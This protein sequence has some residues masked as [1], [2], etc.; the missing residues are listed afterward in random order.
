MAY[1]EK[2]T[3]LLT[4]RYEE[5]F[6]TFDQL[7]LKLS[8]SRNKLSNER[9]SEYLMQGVGR[10]LS[11]L[12]KCV[13]NIFKIFPIDKTDLLLRDDLKD[14]DINLH[15]FFVNIAGIL[16]NLAWV[17]V[18]ENDLFGNPKEGKLSKQ[19]IGLFNKKTQKYF[20]AELNEYLKTDSIKSWYAD[21]SKEYRD[22]LAHRI[23][24]YVPPQAL[25]DEETEEYRALEK[26]LDFTSLEAISRNDEILDRMSS[27]GR[28]CF[29]FAHSLGE[30]CEPVYLHA[31]VISDFIT[32][33][34][35]VNKFCEYGIQ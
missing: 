34:V 12:S 15:A 1:D 27:M 9:A 19:D 29:L 32:I 13:H 24:L 25:S 31:Q 11:V 16:D 2:N 33:D 20:T 26:Q 17:F 3:K 14:L 21:Y 10:R 8:Y 6:H 7:M 4:E 30:G 28:A 22:A 5:V 35:I 23:P 18:Y